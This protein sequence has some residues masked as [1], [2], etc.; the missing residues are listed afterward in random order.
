[1]KSKTM[2]QINISMRQKQTRSYRG[3]NC[4]CQGG[5]RVGE[6]WNGNLSFTESNNYI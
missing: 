4:G 3:Q 6:G 1:M 5:L 2:I